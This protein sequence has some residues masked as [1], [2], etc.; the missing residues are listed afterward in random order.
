MD[1]IVNKVCTYKPKLVE[2]L[3][4]VIVEYPSQFSW[5]ITR[6]HEK[7]NKIHELKLIR[8]LF[9]KI[10]IVNRIEHDIDSGDQEY[11]PLVLFKK[12]NIPKEKFD[13]LLSVY[14]TV[15]NIPDRKIALSII[16]SELNILPL[17]N[18][19]LNVLYNPRIFE[20]CDSE[21]VKFIIRNIQ[22]SVSV[23][24][25]YKRDLI[26]VLLFLVCVIYTSNSLIL[27]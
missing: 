7:K 11:E 14:R 13:G 22:T 23:P 9:E 10:E 21:N 1:F 26:C 25:Q 6:L 8:I 18:G 16:L 2:L 19:L 17:L 24:M 12:H 3:K 20:S 27:V 5:F 15:K 4:N